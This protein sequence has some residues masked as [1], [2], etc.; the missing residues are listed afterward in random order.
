MTTRA[1]GGKLLLPTLAGPGDLVC[2]LPTN[3]EPVLKTPR[4]VIPMYPET[5]LL[6]GAAPG[7]MLLVEGLTGDAKEDGEL[8]DMVSE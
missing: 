1:T 3:L 5:L 2:A 4:R 7:L 8:G 6:P